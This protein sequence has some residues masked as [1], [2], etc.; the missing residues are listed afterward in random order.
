MRRLAN[1]FIYFNV[2]KKIKF[3]RS[4]KVKKFRFENCLDLK[5]L[6]IENIQIRKHS[7]FEKKVKIWKMF[8]SNK[9]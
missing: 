6:K 2:S 4:I 5:M 9:Y 8:K 1:G 7:K 3:E